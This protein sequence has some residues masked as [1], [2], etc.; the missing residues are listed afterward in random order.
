MS[1]SRHWLWPRDRFSKRAFLLAAIALLATMPLGCYVTDLTIWTPARATVPNTWPVEVIRDVV[2]YNGPDKDHHRHKV[3]VFLPRGKKDCPVV[4]LVHG[5]AWMLGDNRCCGLYSSVGEFL[6]SQGIVAVLPNYRL[7]PHVKHPKHIQD[8][9]RA[10]AWTKNYI[11]EFGGRPDE[12]FLLGHSAGGHL[13]S[14]LTT[15]E[16]YLKSEGMEAADIKGVVSVCGVYRIP[17]GNMD[18][19]WGGASQTAFSFDEMAPLRGAGGWSWTRWLGLPG[20][21]LNVNVFGPV[22]G[23][24][25]QVRADAS[26]LNHIR[27]GLPP[28]LIVSAENDLPTLPGMA[29]EFHAA[30]RRQGCASQYLVVKERN[31]NSIIFRAMEPRDPVAEATVDF[32]YQ[33]AF[34]AP[35]PKP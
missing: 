15:D 33:H 13:V 34:D 24:D 25:P 26:P 3:D 31:H 27:P 16:K 14:L 17:P 21:P 9:A 32:I 11:A 8:V 19:D 30:L 6:A 7:S 2:Y 23:D 22:F 5:G 18:V 12:I 29:E 4:L 20:V 28:F 10:F 35:V 1:A